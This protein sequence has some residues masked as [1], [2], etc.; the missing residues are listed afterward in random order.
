MMLLTP[1]MAGKAAHIGQE[2]LL[3]GLKFVAVMAGVVFASRWLV[4]KLLYQVVR[5]RNNELFLLAI[6]ATCMGVAPR[7]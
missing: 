4:P 5:T 1:L 6:L 3:M 7:R 2:L